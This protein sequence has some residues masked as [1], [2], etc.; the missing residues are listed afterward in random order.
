MLF[1]EIMSLFLRGLKFI[2]NRNWLIGVI[3]SGAICVQMAWFCAQMRTV[4]L[5]RY[6]KQGT[7][8]LRD[9]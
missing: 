4:S 8:Y 7:F 3:H 2:Q 5:R 6:H 9:K 1:W